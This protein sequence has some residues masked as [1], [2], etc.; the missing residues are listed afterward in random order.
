MSL[1]Y[2]AS[3][4]RRLTERIVRVRDNQ[5][6]HFCAVLLRLLQRALVAIDRLHAELI[7]ISEW[8][9]DQLTSE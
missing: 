7:L 9:V 5:C 3:A 4:Y 2:P 6:P 1:N 8:S